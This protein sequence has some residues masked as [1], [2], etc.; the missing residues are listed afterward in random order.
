MLPGVGREQGHR[1]GLW[2]QRG[3]PPA[4]AEPHAWDRAGPVQ[5]G[6]VLSERAQ[7]TRP[8]PPVIRDLQAPLGGVGACGAH[9]PL[10]ED[11]RGR[12]HRGRAGL[13]WHP[14]RRPHRRQRGPGRRRHTHEGPDRIRGLGQDRRQAGPGPGTG[15][16]QL[17]PGRRPL[18]HGGPHRRDSAAPD[19]W[20]PHHRGVRDHTGDEPQGRP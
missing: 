5:H 4:H 8:R 11:H 6:L 10:P 9:G 2:T 18:R 17:R 19:G 20:P 3:A 14:L 15:G 7:A 16:G 13:G 1:R 12:V